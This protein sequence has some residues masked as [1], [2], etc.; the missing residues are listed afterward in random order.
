MSTVSPQ[1][2]NLA[3]RLLAYESAQ[4]KPS[5]G[6]LGDAMKV[7]EKFR[8]HLPK[9]VGI[10]GYRSL[11]TRA[12]ALAKAEVPSLGLLQVRTDGSFEGF[13]EMERD[14][15]LEATGNGGLVLAAHLLGLLETFIGRSLTLRLVRDAWPNVPL[16]E[17]D[18]STEEPPR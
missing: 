8:V 1:M 7:C 13:D 2:R 14:Q 4:A 18:S 9:L 16:E 12:L 15:A 5:D 10:G 6:R 11:L 17:L 3:G